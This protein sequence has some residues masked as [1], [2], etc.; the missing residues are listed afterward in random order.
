[1]VS[2][3][4]T[5]SR[6]EGIVALANEYLISIRKP[7]GMYSQIRVGVEGVTRDLFTFSVHV[8]KG[9]NRTYGFET[10][11]KQEGLVYSVR[12]AMLGQLG[13]LLPCPRFE[14]LYSDQVLHISRREFT[15]PFYDP[16]ID[17]FQLETSVIPVPEVVRETRERHRATFR[18]AWKALLK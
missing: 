15:G 13:D 6:P 7:F 17:E 5:S 10:D 11:E 14:A 8:A 3:R 16:S 1:M 18:A 12:N 9:F 4:A 2:F